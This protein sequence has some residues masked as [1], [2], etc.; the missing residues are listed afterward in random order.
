MEYV[1][2]ASVLPFNKKA[3]IMRLEGGG[4]SR[5]PTHASKLMLVRGMPGGRVKFRQVIDAWY[6]NAYML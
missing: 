1:G 3:I 5:A 2:V 4:A 6:K